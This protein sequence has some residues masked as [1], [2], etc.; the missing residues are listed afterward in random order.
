[1]SNFTIAID[2]DDANRWV[3]AGGFPE[4]IPFQL[5]GFYLFTIDAD[6]LEEAVSIARERR[7]R[8]NKSNYEPTDEVEE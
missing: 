6:T 8:R 1:M 2:K 4:T 7:R 5:A 3:V